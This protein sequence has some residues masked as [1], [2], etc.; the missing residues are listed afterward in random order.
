MNSLIIS[1]E[2]KWDIIEISEWYDRKSP[3]LGDRF[4]SALDDCFDHILCEPEINRLLPETEFRR[5]VVSKW[6]YQ[7]FFVFE[8]PM[9]EILAL[10]HTSRGPEHYTERLG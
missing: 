2:A 1:K 10:I 7:I 3:G 6:P 4:L 9:V 5:A 8:P